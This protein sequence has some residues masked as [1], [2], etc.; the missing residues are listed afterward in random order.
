MNNPFE[1]MDSALAKYHDLLRDGTLPDPTADGPEVK[2]IRRELEIRHQEK[3]AE[4][5]HRLQGGLDHAKPVD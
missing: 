2:I 4:M 5:Q 1:Y 3:L